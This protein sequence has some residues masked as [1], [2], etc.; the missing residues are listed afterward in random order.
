MCLALQLANDPFL[1]KNL[2]FMIE[3][4]DEFATEH[5]TYQQH[6]RQV[7]KQQALQQ[8][9]LAKRVQT[10]SPRDAAGGGGDAPATR[11][12]VSRGAWRVRRRPVRRARS[13][14]I[15]NQARQQRDEPPLPLDDNA[16]VRPPPE[17]SRL[18]TLLVSR[19]IDAYCRQVNQFAGHAFSK[20]FLTSSLQ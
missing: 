17:P 13:Q 19:Q 5:Y 1:E 12:A 11:S 15:E 14:K 2:E 7:L 16:A 9:Y 18:E 20:L 6:Q 8:A 10:R 4:T 3:C